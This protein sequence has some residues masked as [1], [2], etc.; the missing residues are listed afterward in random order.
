[1]QARGSP[2]ASAALKT[3]RDI[4]IIEFSRAL[5]GFRLSRAS[6]P[7]TTRREDV[8][9]SPVTGCVR[10]PLVAAVVTATTPRVEDLG[11]GSAVDRFAALQHGDKLGDLSRAR[12]RGLHRADAV[13]DGVAIGSSQRSE[14]S[15]RFGIGVERSR[16]VR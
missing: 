3:K 14:E 16:K 6:S 13:E 9:F 8:P 2:P 5:N 15:S 4:E 7:P 1:M 10:R 12:L 11:V